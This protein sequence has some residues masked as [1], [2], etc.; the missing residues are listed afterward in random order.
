MAGIIRIGKRK[1]QPPVF[2]L[3]CQKEEGVD[4]AEDDRR[5]ATAISGISG[6]KTHELMDRQGDGP[7]QVAN[8]GGKAAEA[9]SAVRRAGIGGEALTP[10]ASEGGQPQPPLSPWAGVGAPVP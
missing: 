2:P 5:T 7:D 10:S 9:E 6:A 3:A 8:S 1:P 4:K